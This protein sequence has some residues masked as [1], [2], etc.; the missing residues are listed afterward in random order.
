MRIKQKR[1]TLLEIW[2][3]SETCIAASKNNNKRHPGACHTS[4]PHWCLHDI[5]EQR[6][7]Q[8]TLGPQPALC[9]TNWAC[10]W[11]PQVHVQWPTPHWK[12]EGN[13]RT[14]HLHLLDWDTYGGL[15]NGTTAPQE[16][17]HGEFYRRTSRTHSA[18]WSVSK[19][20]HQN[21]WGTMVLI[22]G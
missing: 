21:R 20:R 11:S 19:N 9:G 5:Q 2:P 13:D 15:E 16:K 14:L 18:G 3:A 12:K 4:M 22:P 10:L 8:I 1:L 7:P 6:P 17:R